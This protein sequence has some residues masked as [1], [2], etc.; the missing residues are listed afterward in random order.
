VAHSIVLDASQDKAVSL[1]V[2]GRFR[3]ITGGAGTGKT[4]I[5]KAVADSLGRKVCLMAPTGKAAAR[6]REATGYDAGTIHR[7]LLY[8]GVA[9]RRRDPLSVPVIVDEGSMIE[10]ALLAKVLEYNPP[11]LILVGDAAQLPPVGKGQPFHDLV[12]FRPDIVSELS[13]CHRAKGAVHVAAQAIRDGRIPEAVMQSGGE[14]WK[15]YDTG[16]PERT[17]AKL[18][19]W[20]GKGLYDPQQDIILAPRYGESEFVQADLIQSGTVAD[21]GIHSLNRMAKGLLNPSAE[22]EKYRPGDRV[23]INK[24]FGKDDIWNGDLGTVSDI[25]AK[26]MPW[27][28]LDRE[29]VPDEDLVDQKPRLLT[30]EHVREMAHAYALSVHKSQGSQFRRVFFVCFRKH[31]NMLSRALI[32]TAITRAR[33]GA[34]VMGELAAFYRGINQVQGRVTVLQHLAGRAAA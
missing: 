28:V 18:A 16:G 33:E 20:I 31:A 13:T 12:K 27:V 30:K 9:F 3:I 11:K 5:I 26:G 15:M 6:L 21:G 1:A 19:E 8:D 22:S 32:Y 25:D 7:E 34:I 14:T 23:I 24:N 4:T 10:A 2:H 17:V 29:R